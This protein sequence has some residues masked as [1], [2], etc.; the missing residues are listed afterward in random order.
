MKVAW[1]TTN[2]YPN[3]TPTKCSCL[4][5]YE[6]CEEPESLSLTSEEFKITNRKPGYCVLQQ[7]CGK[8]FLLQN[9]QGITR[10]DVPCYQPK[11]KPAL[12]LVPDENKTHFNLV[13]SVCPSLVYQNPNGHLEASVCCSQNQMI[14]LNQEIGQMKQL[15]G[16]LV[17]SC[18]S[19]NLEELWRST[20]SKET[21][22]NLKI[23][24]GAQHAMKTFWI[25]IV[26]QAVIQIRHYG[27]KV[28]RDSKL[29]LIKDLFSRIIQITC[30]FDHMCLHVLTCTFDHMYVHIHRIICI[31]S[32]VHLK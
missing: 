25:F 8:N 3:A 10:P 18:E 15:F 20:R 26:W 28:W 9:G 5:C 27:W 14:N 13:K 17:Y 6:V 32:L 31:R 24:S 23:Y 16:R 2:T 11:T 29:F 12:T 7:T 1:E 19:L 22:L 4:H 21:F 30:A